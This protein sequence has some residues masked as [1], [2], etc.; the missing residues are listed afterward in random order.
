MAISNDAEEWSWRKALG[1]DGWLD[2]WQN[3]GWRTAS[4]ARVS[5]TDLWKRILRWLRL[6]E[7][8]PNRCVEM[9]HVRAHT[10]TKGNERADAL[11]K[12]GAKLRFDLMQAETPDGWFKS[13][14]ERY[15]Q[16]RR[17]E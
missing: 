7:S 6:F 17:P 16:N 2:R 13:A 1:V 11:A 14:L 12:R 8:A 15:W 9:M 4:G 5:H 10:G 3:N